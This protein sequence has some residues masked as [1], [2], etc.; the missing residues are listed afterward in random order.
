MLFCF[1][2]DISSHGESTKATY[3]NYKSRDIIEEENPYVIMTSLDENEQEDLYDTIPSIINRL[4][5]MPSL[6]KN[7]DEKIE[8]RRRR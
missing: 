4:N 3:V 6:P 8:T 7:P 5:T 1:R 2:D